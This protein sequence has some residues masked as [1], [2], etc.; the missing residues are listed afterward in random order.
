[1]EQKAGAHINTRAFI[2]SL[3]ILL[4][5]ML[6]AGFLTRVVPSGSY[7]RIEE[8]GRELIDPA[9]FQYTP[10]PDYPIWR[11][12]TAPV[13]T[14]WGPDSLTIII[15][16][17]FLLLIGSSFA[18]L[19]KSGLMQAALGRIVKTFAGRKYQLLWIVS[20]FFMALG[21][22]FGVCEEVVPLVPL[23]IALSYYLGWDALVGLGMSILAVNMGFSAAITNPFTI[24]VAQNIAGLPLFSGAWFRIFI[25]ATIF[26]VYMLFLSRYARKIEKQP[27]ASPVF[28]EDQVERTKYANLEIGAD[29]PTDAVK[30][31][32]AITWFTI[33]LLLILIILVF[34]SLAPAIFAISLPVVGLLIFIGGIGASMLSGASANKMKRALLE[35]LRGIAPAIPLILMAASIKHIVANGGILDTILHNASQAFSQTSPF[36]ATLMIY[37]LVLFIEVFIGSGSAKAFL[38]MPIILPLADLVDVTRQVAVT[39]YC[40]GDGFSNMAYPTN[41]VLLISLGLTSVGYT[42]W[43]KW[44]WPLWLAVLAVTLVFL[45]ISVAIQLGPF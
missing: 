9:T 23:M 18:V 39:A 3:L 37:F 24:G 34:G 6:A 29:S 30:M 43:I 25:F 40:F 5:L 22:F 36:A 35:G 10:A 45:G 7:T 15:I 12:F 19:D 42:K 32:R 27:Q 41:A 38:V 11:W 2:Q 26:L 14:L 21:A 28:Q 4:I 20:L 44:T 31:R 8:A 13:E 17:I 33:C 16:I 1:M